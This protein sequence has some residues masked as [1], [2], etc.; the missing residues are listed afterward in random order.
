M[1]GLGFR[2]LEQILHLQQKNVFS[3]GQPGQT[4]VLY[5]PGCGAGLF[6]PEIGQAALYLLLL[7]GYTVLLP[8]RHLCCGYPLLA[9]GCSQE[10]Q[11]NQEF[12]LQHLRSLKE[13]ADHWGLRISH[14]LTSCGTCREAMARHEPRL[15]LDSSLQHL[16]VLQLVLEQSHGLQPLLSAPAANKGRLLYH[17]ACHSEWNGVEPEKSGRIYARELGSALDSEVIISPGCCAESGLG[18]LTSPQIYNTLRQRKTKQLQKDLQGVT[19]EAPVLVGCPSCKIGISRIL[20]ETSPRTQVLHSLE[21]LAA[22]AGG[23]D[24]R[25]ELQKMLHSS[26]TEDKMA[27][28]HPGG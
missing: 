6:Y 21:Y 7:S 19:Q 24:W 9:A 23:K 26:K 11:E 8:P 2:N 27:N 1:P 20:L 14:L 3:P 15:Y 17:P 10:Y 25:K 12:N 28:A 13:Q 22:L 16:D 4:A 18:A 5:F